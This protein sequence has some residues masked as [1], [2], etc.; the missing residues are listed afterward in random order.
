MRW[1]CVFD[2]VSES[3]GLAGEAGF[4]PAISNV[5]DYAR[6]GVNAQ[7]FVCPR[8]EKSRKGFCRQ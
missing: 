2:E 5:P 7:R 8:R 1:S 6:S 3:A 4:K